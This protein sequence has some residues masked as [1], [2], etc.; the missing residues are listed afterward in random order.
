MTTTRPN[1][2]PSP[3]DIRGLQQAA[4]DHLFVGTRNAAQLAEDGGPMIVE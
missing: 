3:D 1:T 4:I 2:V